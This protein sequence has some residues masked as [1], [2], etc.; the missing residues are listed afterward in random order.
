MSHINRRQFLTG[1]GAA[2]FLGSTGAL[3]ALAGS[4]AYAADPGGYK[5][6]V[7]VFLFGGMDH[8]DT[9]L[10]YDEAAY[11][12]LANL[13]QGLFAAYGVGSGTS[14]RDRENLLSLNPVNGAS[15][16]ARQFALP[17]ELAPVHGLFETGELSIVAGVGPLLLRP[18][19]GR[20][21]N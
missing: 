7:C 15:F 8:G 12:Q 14:S 16:G 4:R 2:T 20:G 5:A 21:R 3:S 18:T 9:V 17:P 10:P 19:T 13:R 6:L 11:N 1:A